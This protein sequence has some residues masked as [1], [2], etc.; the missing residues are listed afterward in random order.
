MSL[1]SIKIIR[2]CFEKSF[3]GWLLLNSEILIGSYF[4]WQDIIIVCILKK[5]DRKM[6]LCIFNLEYFLSLECELCTLTLLYCSMILLRY[7]EYSIMLIKIIATVLML[8]FIFK[9]KISLINTHKNTI[10]NQDFIIEQIQIFRCFK[11]IITK[12]IIILL[13]RK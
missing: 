3:A 9:N 6:K 13:W 2:K 1:K 4:D 5:S 8:I 12:I 10:F 11:I 7:P